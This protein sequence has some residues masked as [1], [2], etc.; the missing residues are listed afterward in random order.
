MIHQPSKRLN[1]PKNEDQKFLLANGEIIPDLDL[2][3]K[4]RAKP[5]ANTLWAFPDG[6]L[7]NII[8]SGE[9]RGAYMIWLDE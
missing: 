3:V 7:L 6:S 5:V 1:S 8:Q 2:L 4:A 9:A